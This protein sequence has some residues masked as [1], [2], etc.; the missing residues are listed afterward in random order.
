MA[1]EQ[2]A[3]DGLGSMY[4]PVVISL[5]K[6]WI[7][8]MVRG[9]KRHEFRR[10]FPRV[11][12]CAFVYVVAPVGAVSHVVWFGAPVE[13]PPQQIAEIGERERPGGGD[14][15]LEY[16]GSRNTVFAAPVEAMSSVDPLTLAMIRQEVPRFM[17]PQ[18]YLCLRNHPELMAILLSRAEAAV[19]P[20]DFGPSQSVRGCG[21]CHF[22]SASSQPGE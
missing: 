19:N 10:V 20:M 7:D 2:L 17:P 5:K 13:G 22:E 16:F 6:R 1:M 3:M 18:S 9:T 4:E 21:E 12:T 8:E 15:L 14:S 11:A